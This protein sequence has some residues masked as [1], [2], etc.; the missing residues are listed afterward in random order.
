MQEELLLPE[1]HQPLFDLCKERL[2]H[3]SPAKEAVSDVK[4]ASS[5]K[6]LSWKWTMCVEEHRVYILVI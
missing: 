2:V 5:C 4:A 3:W 6:Y 1:K